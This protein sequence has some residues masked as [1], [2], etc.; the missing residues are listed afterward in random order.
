MFFFL[1]F[2]ANLQTKPTALEDNDNIQTE[3]IL[4]VIA[5]HPLCKFRLRRTAHEKVALKT[6]IEQK[7][8]NAG[9]RKPVEPS[10]TPGQN[11]FAMVRLHVPLELGGG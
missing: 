4:K 9:P 5:Q 3:L 10:K 8:D 11:R 2:I 7:R 1:G 6:L